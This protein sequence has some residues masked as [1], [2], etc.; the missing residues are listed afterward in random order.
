[1]L[2]P[3]LI[4]CHILLGLLK[5]HVLFL[6]FFFLFFLCLFLFF[7]PWIISLTEFWSFMAHEISSLMAFW[8]N[9]SHWEITAVFTVGSVAGKIN[10]LNKHSLCNHRDIAI[11]NGQT[12]TTD[13]NSSQWHQLYWCQTAPMQMC[14]SSSENSQEIPTQLGW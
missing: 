3:F 10:T 2:F 5:Y 14:Y 7:H 8:S 11:K 4:I 6:Y 13:S 1:M 9:W 12:D